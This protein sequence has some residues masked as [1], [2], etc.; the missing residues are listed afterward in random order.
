MHYLAW[1][2]HNNVADNGDRNC[3]AQCIWKG[4]SAI[5]CSQRKIQYL[6][7]FREHFACVELLFW[8]QSWAVALKEGNFVNEV[9]KK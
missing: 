1:L 5:V 2:L 3:G 4:K 6:L 9:I 7:V 8:S